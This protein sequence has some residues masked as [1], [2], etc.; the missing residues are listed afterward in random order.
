MVDKISIDAEKRE[1]VGTN[2]VHDLREQ[3][4]LP[5][6]IYGQEGESIPIQLNYRAVEKA[7]NRKGWVYELEFG[8]N[9]GHETAKLKDLQWDHLGEKVLHI[10]FERISTKEP[11]DLRV[12][13]VTVGTSNAIEGSGG[14]LQNHLQS[15]TVSGLPEDIPEQIPIS[16][17]G[18][19]I[20][21]TIHVRDVKLPDNV[22]AV[23][24]GDRLLI[25]VHEAREVLEEEEE[26][27]ELAPTALE[28]EVVGEDEE[29]EEAEEGEEAE[30]T[31][32]EGV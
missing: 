32:E 1:K 22:E 5:G 11:T 7:L 30:A 31:D 15:I 13:L 21:D 2:K 29:E 12:P 9:E 4:I 24:P 3:G 23:T 6:V 14:F 19:G 16:I 10:D 18:I 28:P 17:E 20:G 8:D 27:L 26:E 25:S